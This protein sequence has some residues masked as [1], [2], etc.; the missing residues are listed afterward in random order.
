MDVNIRKRKCIVSYAMTPFVWGGGGGWIVNN[1]QKLAPF[2]R[3]DFVNFK[4]MVHDIFS[5]L[6]IL[7]NLG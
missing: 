4:P 6:Q 5:P 7:H 1:A 3:H 2:F